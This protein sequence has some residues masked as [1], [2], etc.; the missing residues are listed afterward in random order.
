[1]LVGPLKNAEMHVVKMINV[2]R[3]NGIKSWAVFIHLICMGVKVKET[4][5]NSSLLLGGENFCKT[6][7]TLIMRGSLGR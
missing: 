1:M 6:E 2:E 5:F 7:S 4:P 3:G